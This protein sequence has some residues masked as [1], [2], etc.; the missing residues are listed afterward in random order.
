VAQDSSGT[1]HQDWTGWSGARG[2]GTHGGEL[3]DQIGGVLAD[4]GSHHGGLPMGLL[5]DHQDAGI[6]LVGIPGLGHAFYSE[7]QLG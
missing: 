3:I 2:H 4:L 1:G 5:A 6:D 7:F